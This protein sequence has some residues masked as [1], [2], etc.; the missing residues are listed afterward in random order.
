M[1][2]PAL[3]DLYTR[4]ENDPESG[5]AAFGY[6]RQKIVFAVVIEKDGRFHSIPDLRREEQAGRAPPRGGRGFAGRMRRAP[7]PHRDAR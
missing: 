5:I 2:I 7:L 1:I 3:I 6:S 4:L